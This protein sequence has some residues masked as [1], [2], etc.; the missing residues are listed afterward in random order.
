[1]KIGCLGL[2]LQGA[3]STD[4]FICCPNGSNTGFVLRPYFLWDAFGQWLSKGK[5]LQQTHSWEMLDSSYMFLDQ[6]FPIGL[7]QSFLK[8]PCCQWRLLPEPSY[9]PTSF[10]RSYSLK[11][12]S[13]E[14]SLACM[15]SYWH[16]LL[17]GPK[18]GYG[19]GSRKQVVGWGCGT[20]S[21]SKEDA[22][23]SRSILAQLAGP[24]TKCS[25]SGNLVKPFQYREMPSQGCD[26]LYG[27][28]IWGRSLRWW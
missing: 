2:Q 16:M 20:S 12:P 15:I 1:M 19:S 8:L 21:L 5:V 14:K 11:T 26:D 18:S 22:T 25:T 10:H 13:P 23:L 6:E 24:T 7:V 9:F 3:E 28:E 4:G 17:S 27:W